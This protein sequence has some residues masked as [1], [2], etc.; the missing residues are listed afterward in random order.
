MAK[1]NYISLRG[2]LKNRINL[3]PGKDG[4]VSSVIFPLSVVRRSIYDRAGALAPRYD[5]PFIST[6]DPDIIRRITDERYGLRENDAVEVKGIFR[7]QRC[8]RRVICPH[9]GKQV[10]VEVEIQTV[11]PTFVDVLHHF[12]S[13]RECKD[14]LISCAE[15]SNV[16]KVLGRVCTPTDEIY[17]G[18]NDRGDVFARYKIAVN[19]KLYVP[20]SENADDHTDY[21]WVYSFGDTAIDDAHTLQQGTLVYLDGYLHTKTYSQKTTCDECGT[22]FTFEHQQASLSPYSMEYLRDYAELAPST[23]DEFD[24]GP[25]EFD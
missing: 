17:I 9:C 22:E 7:T 15:V 5:V 14:Y 6:N 13:S 12:D 8:I 4:S 11:Y 24:L 2:Q 18:E 10:S 16:A 23:H 19:R 20:G 25:G 21:P 3:S 1:E